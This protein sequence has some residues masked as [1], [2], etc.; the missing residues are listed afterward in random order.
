MAEIIGRQ[1][2]KRYD[3]Y[4][5]GPCSFHVESGK[6]LAVLGPSGSGK[7]TLLRICAGLM[8]CEGEIILK[9]V[10]RCVV[11]F[12]EAKCLNTMK[13]YDNIVLGMKKEGY[14]STE[15]DKRINELAIKIGLSD[16]LNKYPSELS[17]GQRQRVGLARALVRDF[18]VLLMDEPFSGLDI[19][20][21]KDMLQL[22]SAMQKEKQFSCI[23]VTHDVQDAKVFSDQVMILKDGQIEMLASV[24]ECQKNPSSPFVEALFE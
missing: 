14:S 3:N 8:F 10:K 7:S 19:L 1:V 20:L 18:D 21:R 9:D 2:I 5:V 12:D 22:I 6:T 11:V 13:V 17:Y 24:E 4:V 23:Y 15:I 16:Q